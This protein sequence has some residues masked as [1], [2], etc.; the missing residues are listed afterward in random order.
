MANKKTQVEGLDR[1]LTDG[2]IRTLQE[3]LVVLDANLCVIFASQAFYDKFK[4]K[5]KDIQGRPFY[6]IDNNL[7][8]NPALRTLLEQVIPDETDVKEY[9]VEHNFDEVGK[10]IMII[11]QL[12]RT[13]YSK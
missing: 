11:K 2:I 4:I 12:Q 3:P 9:E 1:R 13:L 8:G 6:E 5:N 7:W 10:R